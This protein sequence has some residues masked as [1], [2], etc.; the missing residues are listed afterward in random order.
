MDNLQYIRDAMESSSTFTSVPGVGGVVVGVSALIT[1]LAASRPA[2]E[3]LWLPIW[4]GDAVVAALIGALALRKK[5]RR[6]EVQ[7]FRGLGRKFLLSLCP[8]VASA[9]LL[10]AVL[11][12]VGAVEAIPGTWL[13]LWGVGVMAAGAFSVRIVPVMGACFITLGALALLT[14]PAWSNLLLM[15]GFGGL[16][17]IFGV[18]V[19]RKHG[20]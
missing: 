4:L 16:H 15:A 6:N 17:I 14:P 3:D 8:P 18:L 13:L 10:T 11:Y 7:L 5:A 20:G 12:R 1:G 2:W 19:A 9:L